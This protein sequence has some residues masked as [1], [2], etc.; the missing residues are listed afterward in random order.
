MQCLALAGFDATTLGNHEFD[1]GPQG[2]AEAI[3][4]A[5][6]A[7]NIPM[8]IASNTN[9]EANDSGI[10]GLQ[11]LANDGTILRSKIIERGGIRFGLF[12]IMGPDSIQF[13]INPGAVTFP[14]TIE[15][16]KEMTQQLRKD[17][18][19]IIICMSHG[20]VV[21]SADGSIIGGDDLTLADAV[22]EIDVIVGGHTHNFMHEPLIQNG[23]PIVQA[24]CYGQGVGELVM[25]MDGPNLEVV[26]YTLHEVN[27]SIP[28]NA[29]L[30]ETVNTFLA[31]TSQIVFEPRNLKSEEVLAI[32]DTD[33]PNSFSD[34]EAS[35]PAWYRCK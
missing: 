32:I 13:T 5:K 27:D 6:A 33:W 29:Q 12:G 3:S 22:P 19:D 34:L 25:S 8:I 17:G 11:K 26:S 7:G 35:R 9:M 28:G 14:E 16:A 23:I 21:A 1:N 24:G 18:A 10:A 4:A 2:L 30:N 15:T 31:T 20:G